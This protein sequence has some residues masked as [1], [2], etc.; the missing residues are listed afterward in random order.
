MT[1]E[2]KDDLESKIIKALKENQGGL[3]SIPLLCEK[4]GVLDDSVVASAVGKLVEK[5]VVTQMDGSKVIYREDGG[6]INLVL[7][8]LPLSVGSMS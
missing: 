5:G 1:D 4:I 6:K 3:L 7:Y 2:N 8:S